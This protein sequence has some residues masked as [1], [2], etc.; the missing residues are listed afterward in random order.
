MWAKHASSKGMYLPLKDSAPPT[1]Q[2]LCSQNLV[3]WEQQSCHH[4]LSL[5]PGYFPSF[6]G[7]LA[8]FCAHLGN[9][10]LWPQGKVGQGQADRGV[11]SLWS[12]TSLI[13]QSW[14]LGKRTR[15]DAGPRHAGSL[16]M[17]LHWSWGRAQ[18]R[19]LRVSLA[20]HRRHRP[21][22]LLVPLPWVRELD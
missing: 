16:H 19:S 22:E 15:D 18:I 14:D 13:V 1:P 20:D 11:F 3:L 12:L 5:I 17:T 2:G 4:L 7:S 8:S 10:C 6:P 21:E 9:I